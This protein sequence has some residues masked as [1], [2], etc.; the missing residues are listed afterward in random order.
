MYHPRDAARAEV[1]L[2]VLLPDGTP[3]ELPE[4]ATGRDAA[5]AIGPGL[6]RAAVAVR[7]GDE[8]RDLARPLADGEAIA[9]ITS[10]SGADY[11]WVMRHSAAHVMAEAVREVVPGAKLGFG[12]PIDDGFYYDFDLPR[13]LSEDD[14]PAIEA[15]VKRIKKAKAPFER[16]L[17]AMDE[18]KAFFAERGE[19]FKVDQVEELE[20]QGE[21]EV[22]IYTQNGFVDLCR[23]GHVQDTGKVGEV[24]LLSLA[25][26]YWRGSEK[27]PQLT[28][29]YATAFPTSKELDEHLERLEQ[30]K[31]RDHRRL[32]KDL[33]I[34]HFD[35]MGPGF[36]FYLPNGMVLVNG[37][38]GAVRK[39]LAAM[40]Y[41]EI[42]TPTILSDQLWHESGHWENYKENMY[43]TEVDGQTFAVKPM[44]CPGA[45]LV[46]RSQRHS[47]RDLPIRL[48]EFGH[49][50]RH[51]LSGVLHG[52]FR[53]RAFTQDDAH[54][55]CR[56]DQ[57]KGEVQSVLALIDRFYGRFGFDQVALRLGTRPEKALGS[58]E[59]WEAAEAAL[60]DALEG[61][62]YTL[63]AGDGAFYGPKI[64]FH[65]TDT[66]GRAWQL[67]T[68]QLDF[69]MPERFGL[70]YT[71]A[72]DTDERPVIIHRAV[73][74]STERFLGILIE[75]C[76]GDFPFWL[77]PEQ[78]RVLPIADRHAETAEAVAARL[79]SEGLRVKADARSESLGRRIRDGELQKVPYLLIVGDR[80]QEAGAV[81][82]R[83]RAAGDEGSLPLED[84]VARL[85]A[86]DEA[87]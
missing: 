48:A 71:T 78:A 56:L 3:L 24:K 67:G 39:E 64:D 10:K 1:H 51:E 84:L 70:T 60:V 19:P 8:I 33:G 55:F 83:S 21:T 57:V 77:A 47:Y 42:Q 14:F 6:A 9:I 28:R 65:V 41:D 69:F 12:P 45:C 61:R 13:P 79:R 23:G 87:D 44:N 2:R 68:C 43:F 17:M 29:L 26:A 85:R 4:G 59:M 32:G 49:V 40:G 20:R 66:M 82:V 50:H 36:P 62:E 74:G 27:N 73:T 37:I 11:L 58:A 16:T 63:N 80:E 25:G 81:G 30:A 18:A 35:E 7:V 75:N 52:L 76:G 34:F 31:A 22:S 5:A 86:E 38:R 54:I 46:Y 15:A 53:V 72:E